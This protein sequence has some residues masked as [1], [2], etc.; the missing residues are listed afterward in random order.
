MKK[1]AWILL[2]AKTLKMGMNIENIKVKITFHMLLVKLEVNIPEVLLHQ[3]IFFPNN[4][5]LVTKI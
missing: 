5:I 1:L 4:T 2:M 3:N